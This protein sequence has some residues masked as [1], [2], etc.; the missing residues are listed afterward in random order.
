MTFDKWKQIK[1]DNHDDYNKFQ[2]ILEKEIMKSSND[3]DVDL[4]IE[5]IMKK[6]HF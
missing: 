1:N 2:T 5:N 4:L 6:L 3:V